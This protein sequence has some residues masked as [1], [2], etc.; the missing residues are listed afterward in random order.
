MPVPHG[1]SHAPAPVTSARRRKVLFRRERLSKRPI[2]LG[3]AAAPKAGFRPTS[4]SRGNG[5]D[6]S[7]QNHRVLPVQHR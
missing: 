2:W 4:G 5:K 3:D 6:K 7:R 1:G